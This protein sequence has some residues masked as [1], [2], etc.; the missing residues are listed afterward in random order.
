MGL[1]SA[2]VTPRGLVWAD[3]VLEALCF[4]WIDSKSERVDDFARRQ[5]WT[6]RRTGSIWSLT[7][8]A[9]VERLRGEGR[10]HPAGLAAFERRRPDRTGIYSFE[11]G[12]NEFPPE[13]AAALLADGPA[14][15]FWAASTQG[16]RRL[17]THWVTSAKQQATRERRMQALLDCCAAGELIPSQRY[18]ETP[19][20]L[21]RARAAR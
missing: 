19:A 11:A 3:A 18:G 13:F 20:W 16:Y 17:A 2:E 8:V 21:A 15:R 9:H 1:N 5:R 10:L 4:G 7:N 12:G 6:P 14:G